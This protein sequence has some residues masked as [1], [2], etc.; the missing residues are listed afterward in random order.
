M[1]QVG[2][3]GLST[4]VLDELKHYPNTR[5]SILP[6]GIRVA[7]ERSEGE[8]ATVGVHINAGSRYEPEAKNGVAHFLEHLMFKGTNRRSRV[9]LE[10]EIENIGAT[11]NAYTSREQTVYYAKVQRDDVNQGLDILSDMM[12]NS[13]LEPSAV[14]NERGVILREMEEIEKNMM[15]VSFD[16]LHH[17]AYRGSSLARTILGPVEN[18]KTIT[19]EDVRD[20]VREHYTGGRIVISAAGQI[21]H[22]Q[23]VATAEKLFASVPP[24]GPRGV[25][26][27]HAEFIGSDIIVREDDMPIAH[28]AYAFETAGWTD[29]DYYTLVVLQFLVDSYAKSAY[30]M[31][32]ATSPIVQKIATEDC[33]E[34]MTPFHTCYSDTGLFGMY[35]TAD[36]TDL[37][38]LM[39]VVPVQFIRMVYNL[40][41]VQLEEAK[42]KAKLATLNTLDNTTSRADEVGR[43]VL[44]LGRRMHPYE[45]IKR[46]DAIDIIAVQNC[47]RRFFYDRDHA[48]AATGPVFELPDYNRIRA[49]SYLHML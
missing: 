27:P 26:T 5:I 42:N 16:R 41:P 43:Q 39:S 7:T 44:T 31:N 11:V 4:T 33:A 30:G 25:P 45:A 1:S 35:L 40:T 18:I 22:D 20:Y 8:S 9:Q 19:A 47:L 32:F 2:K 21:D 36:A 23:L 13:K 15:E 24:T 38:K 48:L 14:E 12:L 6:N 17:T 46:I 10:T 49:R 3:R 28:I 37:S 34:T 29:P